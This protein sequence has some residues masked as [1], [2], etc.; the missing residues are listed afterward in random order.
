MRRCVLWQSVHFVSN[1]AR[2]ST[3]LFFLLPDAMHPSLPPKP[4]AGFQAQANTSRPQKLPMQHARAQEMYS[5]APTSQPVFHAVGGPATYFSN[6]HGYQPIVHAASGQW[7]Q[8]QDMA[9]SPPYMNMNGGYNMYHDMASSSRMS[10]PLVN[11]YAPQINYNILP[12]NSR[13]DPM[14]Y[15]GD[16]GAP[17]SSAGTPGWNGAGTTG[18]VRCGHTGCVFRASHKDVEVH[19][20][21]R[22]LIYPP[23]WAEQQKKQ[24]RVSDDDDLSEEQIAAKRAGYVAVPGTSHPTLIP[25]ELL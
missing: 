22:H 13:G 23:G 20:M 16:A 15:A 6:A 8:Q 21:D 11:P 10:N 7:H 1:I 5:Q 17:S 12:L 4:K 18:P 9:F 14:V 19:R 24:K 2:L 3:M 25:L